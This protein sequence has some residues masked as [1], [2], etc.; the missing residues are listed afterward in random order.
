MFAA[1]KIFAS[2]VNR[3]TCAMQAVVLKKE[4]FRK[5]GDGACLS[6]QEQ[7]IAGEV[8]S[9]QFWLKEIRQGFFLHC[10]D[11]VH[12]QAMTSRFLL[13]KSGLKIFLKL[14][15]SGHLRHL[16]PAMLAIGSLFGTPQVATPLAH[17]R[18][19][20]VRFLAPTLPMPQRPS[21]KPVVLCANAAAPYQVQRPIA[22][23]APQPQPSVVRGSMQS[24]TNAAEHSDG[25]N[26]RS[27]ATLA[28]T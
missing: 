21:A 19:S 28:A 25:P 2:V 24:S 17:P 16:H 5:I 26:L 4:L 1:K 15:G 11:V 12:L 13:S 10:T 3:R 20:T 6:A 8:I 23:T 27:P 9:G 7:A 18:L 14:Q 22:S